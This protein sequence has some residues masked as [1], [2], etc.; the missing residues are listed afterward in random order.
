MWGIS[1]SKSQLGRIVGKL[2]KKQQSLSQ[3][4]LETK[5]QQPL[6]NQSQK[7]QPQI[8]KHRRWWCIEVDGVIV[9]TQVDGGTEW[10]EVKNAVIYPM[11]CPSQ[12]HY[13]SQL[14]EKD[15][16]T[17]LVH[18]L[19]RVAGVKPQDRLIGIT[20][21]ASWIAELMGDLG[22]WR[23]VLDV[24]HAAQ[25]LE[26]L[27]LGMGW[28]DD[29]RLSTR[30][31]LLRGQLDLQ[32]WLNHHAPDPNTLSEGGQKA[33]AYLQK[34]TLLG[35]TA[36]PHFIAD[37]I[38]VIGSGQIE[39]A[40]KHVIGARLKR[41]GCRWKP[42]GASAKALVR[43]QFFSVSELIPF[44]QVRFAAFPNAA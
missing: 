36:Y 17:P 12:R 18:G 2:D 15:G 43:S 30:R 14:G 8:Q 25:Y 24:Y 44:D 13:V 35:H 39:G 26:T 4:L 21:G 23:H 22:V 27:M 28:S 5:A 38:E 20:D 16:F 32:A 41:S 9:P 10:R 3:D 11:H 29:S 1:T 34:Q 42:N 7:A 31:S 6:L 19:L 37:G 33:L 40:N